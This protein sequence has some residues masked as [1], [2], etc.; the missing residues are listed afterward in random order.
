[1]RQHLAGGVLAVGLLV[2]S[3]TEAHFQLQHPA[4]WLKT[5]STG[6]PAGTTGTQKMNP[7][8]DGTR[9]GL[10]TQVH[11]GA[12]LHVKVTE[13]IAHGGHYRIAIVPKLDPTSDEL[14]EPKVT[15]QSG[16][17]TTADVMSPVAPPVLADGLFDHAQATAVDG[18]VWETDI[19][20]PTT[21]GDATLQVLEFMTP[22]PPQCFYH[23]CARLQIVSADTD[24]GPTGEKVIG[25]SSGTVDAGGSSSGDTTSGSSSSSGDNPPSSS[26]GGGGGGGCSVAND[27]TPSLVVCALGA[28]AVVAITRQ[29]RRRRDP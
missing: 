13:A 6:D 11:A 1:M 3:N 16:S 25:A 10:V 17:C 29:R 28:F 23:H 14:A 20:L 8:G 26:G 4:D 24:L 15:L 9:T 21:T 12:K 19:T 18:Q 5:D 22:H 7:C 2:A 27:A